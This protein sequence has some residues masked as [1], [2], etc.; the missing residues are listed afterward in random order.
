MNQ[1]AVPW[2]AWFGDE[3]KKLAFPNCWN[4]KLYPM[5]DASTLNIDQIRVA[6]SNPYGS[7]TINELAIGK[8][9][10]AIAID[11]LSRPTPTQILMSEIIHQLLLGGVKKEKIKFI[12]A[13]GAHRPLDKNEITKKLGKHIC[14]NF[15]VI[16][17]DPCNDLIDIGM[18]LSNKPVQINKYFIEANLKIVIGSV[19]PH[20]F[21]GYSGGAKMIFPGLAGISAVEWTHKAAL[22]GFAGKLGDVNNSRFR[23]RA[24]EIASKVGI[25]YAINVV[26]NSSRKIAG[27]FS[28]DIIHSHRKA[29]DF[30]RSVFTTKIPDDILDVAI[31]NAYPKD[32]ELYQSETAL[33]IFQS[34][35][36]NFVKKNGIV[37]ITSACSTGMGA[38]RL[39]EPGGLLYRVPIKKSFLADRH[40]IFFSPNI[41]KSEFE[42]LF[43]NGYSFFSDWEE[44]ISALK[45]KYHD[46]CD[47]AIFPQ[48]TLQ[49]S[50]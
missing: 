4:V 46:K 38:H 37:V 48:G 24:E 25:D 40:L 31:F 27:I 15:Q 39:F 49:L 14:Q 41:K 50:D 10:V 43:W 28:G 29:V 19:L 34:A 9:S 1:F 2:K 20:P 30:A 35:K 7:K 21:A 13:L 12:V 33:N 11:D 23:K 22:M 18:H 44:V 16:N 32:N 5:N 26:I 36:G 3:G 6:F 17:H 47:I 45:L 42:A 8:K